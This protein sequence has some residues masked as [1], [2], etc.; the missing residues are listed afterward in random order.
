M[1]T[2]QTLTTEQVS[3][4]LWLKA[5]DDFKGEGFENSSF[6]EKYQ[7]FEAVEDTGFSREEYD[8]YVDFWINNKVIE[9]NSDTQELSITKQGQKLF[10]LINAEG[11]K[12]DAEIKE[13]LQ[14]DLLKTPIDKVISCVKAHP[15]EV[16]DIIGL[17]LQGVQIII[18]TL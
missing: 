11:D 3:I 16:I 8:N 17:C 13:V 2:Q 12:S 10:E 9:V 6:N 15:Q 5:L 7:A 1:G 18:S 14:V 4:L